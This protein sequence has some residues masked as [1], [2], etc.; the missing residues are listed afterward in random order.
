[1][2]MLMNTEVVTCSNRFFQQ[3]PKNYAFPL[4]IHNSL[5]LDI[6]NIV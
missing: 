6:N 4:N 3:L 5:H 2:N 1:M